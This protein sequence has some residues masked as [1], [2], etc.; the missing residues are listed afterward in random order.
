[1]QKLR[2]AMEPTLKACGISWEE[3]DD[4]GMLEVSLAGLQEALV[5]ASRRLPFNSTP[6]LKYLNPKP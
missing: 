2:D 6:P 5:D 1:M 4:S 3:V